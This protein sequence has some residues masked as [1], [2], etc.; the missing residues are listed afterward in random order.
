METNNNMEI[1]KDMKGLKDIEIYNNMEKKFFDSIK[2]LKL[3]GETIAKCFS[4]IERE[5]QKKK[6]KKKKKKG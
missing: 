1:N 2:S 3:S 6:K 4:I 5:Q